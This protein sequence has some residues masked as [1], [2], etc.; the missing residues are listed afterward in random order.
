MISRLSIENP[1]IGS[2]MYKNL[3]YDESVGPSQWE[4]VVLVHKWC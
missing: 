4:E 3:I 2:S 1:E